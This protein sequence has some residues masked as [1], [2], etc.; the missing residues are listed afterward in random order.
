MMQRVTRR[1]AFVLAALLIGGAGAWWLLQGGEPDRGPSYVAAAVDRGPITAEVTATGT[2]NPVETVQVGTYV[3]GPVQTV[4]A[5]FN[6][7]VK[8]GQLLATI[9]SR[10]FELKV[11]AA[12][13]ELANARA[14]LTKGR[15]D[16][17]LKERTWKRQ[18]DLRGQ[19]IVSQSD[20]DTAESEARQAEAQI[21]LAAAAV[22]SAE[23]R[24][25]EARVNLDYTRIVSPVDGVVVSRNVSVGQTVAASFQTPTLFL[26]A[27]DLTKM[28]VSASVSESDIGGVAVG[29][30]VNFTVDA[31]PGSPFRGRV[32]QVRN[33][34]VTVQNVVTYDVLVAVDNSELRLKPGMTA[35]VSITTATRDDVIRIPTAA[36]RFRPPVAPGG[37]G[38]IA[39]APPS[40]GHTAWVLADDGTLHPVTVTTGIADERFTEV[41]GGLAQG[42]RVVTGLART[43]ASDAPPPRSPFMP[44]VQRRG[45]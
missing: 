35:N 11:A 32:S 33:S 40:G 6:T 34:P 2:V 1:S 45:R 24:L 5:D 36:L 42:D 23:A 18:R 21:A 17:D 44:S 4:S 15:A 8:K 25:A 7:P 10:P 19:G 20:L 31:Y 12:E 37:E 30:V 27:T 28:E 22:R 13:A 14:A 43:A 3:S 38:A 29:Q 16:L 26:V 39:A 41:T 9:D